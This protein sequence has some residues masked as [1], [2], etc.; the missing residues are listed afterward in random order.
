MSQPLLQSDL[1][2]R[3]K[4]AS[5]A[6]SLADGEALGLSMS[7]SHEAALDISEKLVPAYDALE[8][9]SLQMQEQFRVAVRQQSQQSSFRTAPSFCIDN[10][11]YRTHRHSLRGMLD[12]AS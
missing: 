8:Q 12:S 2:M 3:E 9:R 10:F 5:I 1:H 7:Q 6:T 4:S 11:V